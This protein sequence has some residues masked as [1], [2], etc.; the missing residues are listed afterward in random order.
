MV[1]AEY[2]ETQWQMA[3]CGHSRLCKPLVQTEGLLWLRP[4]LLLALLDV[5]GGLAAICFCLMNFSL[6]SDHSLLQSQAAA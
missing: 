3:C 5:Q 4:N 6:K 2:D 1:Y